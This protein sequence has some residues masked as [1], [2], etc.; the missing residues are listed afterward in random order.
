MTNV[1]RCGRVKP[2][3]C[4]WWDQALAPLEREFIHPREPVYTEGSRRKT[5]S[6]LAPST[7]RVRER[8]AR[9]TASNLDTPRPRGRS[10][11]RMLLSFQRP[12]HLFKK[13][14]PPQRRAR[15]P[16]TGSRG[17]P[18]IVARK[19]GNWE[20]AGRA[21]VGA[22]DL[23]AATRSPGPSPS[24]CAAGRRSRSARLAARSL[25]RG[26]PR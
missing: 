20:G 15:E 9:S 14:D 25:A 5:G 2:W 7:D 12:S 8:T 18:V 13:G 26:D 1:I 10:K 21:T 11:V 23:Q 6:I 24:A 16:R 22:T 4:P 17:G 3:A 19:V